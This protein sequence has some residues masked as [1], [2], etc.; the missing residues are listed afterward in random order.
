[1]TLIAL[2]T[3]L[4]LS[5]GGASAATDRD[6]VQLARCSGLAVGAGQDASVFEARMGDRAAKPIQLRR[7]ADQARDQAR[8]MMR[9]GDDA[10][11]AQLQA[12]LAGRCVALTR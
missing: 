12:E 8:L 6:Y 4:A 10:A 9:R 2:F 1:M 11:R 3:A 5:S 7:Q